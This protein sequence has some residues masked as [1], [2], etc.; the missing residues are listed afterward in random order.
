MFL[1]M[2][3]VLANFVIFQV[4]YQ[5]KARYQCHG[6]Y[7]EFQSIMQDRKIEKDKEQLELFGDGMSDF[8]HHFAVSQ[9]IFTQDMLE[10]YHQYI[11]E[12]YGTKALQEIEKQNQTL[13]HDQSVA[14][15]YYSCEC[16]KR[17][18]YVKEYE[19][20]R[21][22][23]GKDDFLTVGIFQKNR[24]FAKNNIKK[25]KEAYQKLGT[26]EIATGNHYAIYDFLTYSYSSVFLL[27]IAFLIATLVIR[28]EEDAGLFM[29]V[30]SQKKGRTKLILAKL[31]AL[32]VV[33]FVFDLLAEGSILGITTYFFYDNDWNMSIQSIPE[34]RNCCMPLKAWQFALLCVS[35]RL[36]IVYVAGVFFVCLFLFFRKNWMIYLSTGII[37]GL[38][39]LGYTE[40]LPNG[41]FAL[42]KYANVF[43]GLSP[44]NLYGTYQNIPIGSYPISTTV[45][46]WSFF[47]IFFVCAILVAKRQWN[48]GTVRFAGILRKKKR[49]KTRGKA[50]VTG[51]ILY[52]YFIQ[53]KKI[54]FCVLVLAL[55]INTGC[56]ESVVTIPVTLTQADYQ[57]EIKELQGPLTKETEKAIERKDNFFEKL[58]ERVME[59]EMMDNPTAEEQAEQI[60][61]ET[62]TGNPYAAH[63]ELKEQYEQIK[64]RQ[65]QGKD[66]QLLDTYVW[67]RLFQGNADEVKNFMLA[68]IFCVIVCGSIFENKKNINKLIATTKYGRR[69]LWRKQYILGIGCGILAWCSFLLPEII[70]FFRINPGSYW[71]ASV[72][73]LDIM[74]DTGLEY[75]IGTVVF[76]MYFARLLVCITI[77]VGTMFFVYLTDNMFVS[78]TVVTAGILGAGIVLL[79]KQWGVLCSIMTEGTHPLQ[80]LAILLGICS[81]ILISCIVFWEKEVKYKKVGGK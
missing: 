61:L 78:M 55:G 28:T 14:Y 79:K 27:V 71:S 21:N 15:L 64:K 10:E 5:G 76:F 74:A 68:G 23:I 40:I 29:L 63:L 43:Q 34:F 7:K 32:F 4:L 45:V 44:A 81:I 37:F 25:T 30:K 3:L 24:T 12:T 53:E 66:V 58:W 54:V 1:C 11:I 9:N 46:Y 49:K 51:S 22:G 60:A 52:M 75:S 56:L 41:T 65:E 72:G 47:V 50:T 8:Q 77:A 17:L 36:L 73:N 19:Q 26:M 20:F 80:N 16:I 2:V 59:L 18:D 57:E 62:Q 39:F 67:N 38:F 31:L 13:T 48:H 6:Y 70:R 69:H 35:T 33:L 42:F